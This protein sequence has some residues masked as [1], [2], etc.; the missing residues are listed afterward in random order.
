MKKNLFI[1]CAIAV[2]AGSN[3]ASLTT[4]FVGGNSFAGNMVDVN[5]LAGGGIT[6]TGFDIHLA[7]DAN[8]VPMVVDIYTRTGTY[9]GNHTSSAGWTLMGSDTVISA[10][11]G[12]PTAVNIGG[13]LSAGVHGMF[14]F[15][16]DWTT[17]PPSN[18][19]PVMNYTNLN[20]S[21]HFY[22]N[23]D[24]TITGG[25]GR[26]NSV[27]GDPFASGVF[28]SPGST[29][30]GRMWNGTIHYTTVPEPATMT[31]LGLGALALIRKRKAN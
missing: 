27:G 26:G 4:T 5:V 13:A 21:N 9:V 30:N 15:L 17:N 7:T 29:T 22:S 14:V 31:L 16:R 28:G 11:N 24:L 20:G 8:S 12:N 19:G 25:I 6:I 1:A 3:A 10:G 23:A 2:A 18:G